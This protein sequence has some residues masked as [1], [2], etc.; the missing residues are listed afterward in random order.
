MLVRAGTYLIDDTQYFPC[1]SPDAGRTQT[2]TVTVDGYDYTPALNRYRNWDMFY[3]ALRDIFTRDFL[4][5]SYLASDGYCLFRP[6]DGRMYYLPTERG[7]AAGYNQ[8][9]TT[10]TFTKLEET[11]EKIAIR[12]TASMPQTIPAARPSARLC[13]MDLS[14]TQAPTPSQWY[15][16]SA[17]GGLHSLKCRFKSA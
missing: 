10:M 15:G 1:E 6:I 7:F 17:A 12:V 9:T 16:R 13:R 3:A 2:D 11:D 4:D 8:V 5:D 14:R